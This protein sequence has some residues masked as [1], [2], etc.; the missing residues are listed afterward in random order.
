MSNTII[1]NKTISTR[2]TS[3]ISERAKANLAKQG[4]TVSEYIRLSLVKAANNEVR[5]VSFLDSPEASAAKKEAETGQVKNIGSLTDFE[6][7]I[8]KLDAN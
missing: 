3:D 7:W 2:V 4:L 1:K 8:D 5:L 6:D